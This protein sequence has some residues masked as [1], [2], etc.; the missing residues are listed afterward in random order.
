LH[1]LASG[2]RQTSGVHAAKH[3][4]PSIFHDWLVA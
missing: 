3:H 1:E 2:L 4:R